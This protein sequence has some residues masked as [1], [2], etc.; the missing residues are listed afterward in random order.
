MIVWLFQHA[1]PYHKHLP[2]CLNWFQGIGTF[3]VAVALQNNSWLQQYLHEM[4]PVIHRNVTFQSY[5]NFSKIVD[6]SKKW[7]MLCLFSSPLARHL[8]KC[9]TFL[10]FLPVLV[11]KESWFTGLFFCWLVCLIKYFLVIKNNTDVFKCVT[12]T[13]WHLYLWHY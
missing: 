3:S 13:L 4:I 6:H 8:C 10:C 7:K 5:Q 9:Y 12:Q 2:A 1:G 11:A